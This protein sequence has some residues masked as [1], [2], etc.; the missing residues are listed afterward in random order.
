MRLSLL[1]LLF[2]SITFSSL[3][4][5]E[6]FGSVNGIC[7]SRNGTVLTN[8]KIKSSIDSTRSSA[9]GMFS[10]KI[11]SNS[12][13]EI[14]F[15]YQGVQL[16]KKYKLAPNTVKSIGKIKLPIQEERTVII[17]RERNESEGI[18][19]LPSLDLQKIPTGNVE[20]ALIFTTAASSNNELTANYNVRGGSYDE[21]TISRPCQARDVWCL[22]F[23]AAVHVY[24]IH[25]G[26]R[27]RCEHSRLE[28]SDLGHHDPR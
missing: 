6:M 5:Q 15:T 13:E 3:T 11:P 12:S 1:F 9:E 28:R 27:R 2:T 8:V 23:S 20:R 19:K 10:L 22:E 18:N 24:Q 17:N 26:G 14:S 21:K 7:I 25:C 4:Q 16:N